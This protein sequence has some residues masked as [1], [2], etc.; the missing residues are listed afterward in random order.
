MLQ[1]V[2]RQQLEEDKIIRQSTK[3]GQQQLKGG[4]AA[5]ESG[6]MNAAF[7]SQESEENGHPTSVTKVG[8]QIILM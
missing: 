1:F 4:V 5:R 7:Q 8:S 3:R 6:E 2:D